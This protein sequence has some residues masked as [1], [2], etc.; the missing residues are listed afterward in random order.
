MTG[1]FAVVIVA[2]VAAL[3]ATLAEAQVVA[4]RGSVI[5]SAPIYLLRNRDR[6]PL[7]TAP[8]GTRLDVLTRAGDWIQV[9]FCD[10]E[11]GPRVGFIEAPFLELTPAGEAHPRDL[12]AVQPGGPRAASRPRATSARPV[13]VGGNVS[14]TPFYNAFAMCSSL[15]VA[16]VER[17]GLG[18]TAH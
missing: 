6:E 10:P 8:E 1:R 12:S 17:T 11:F 4:N 13:R 14:L 15:L 7:R 3:Q 16:N 5:V 18:I 9:R 2:A